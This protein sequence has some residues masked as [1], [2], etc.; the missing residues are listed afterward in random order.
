MI[1]NQA[2]DHTGAIIMRLR[3]GYLVLPFEKILVGVEKGKIYELAKNIVELLEKDTG[4][5]VLLEPVIAKINIDNERYV[6]TLSI[7]SL[8]ISSPET[9]DSNL[10]ENIN[11]KLW[12]IA[13]DVW[14]KTHSL[15]KKTNIYIHGFNYTK[16][17][18]VFKY[19][20]SR[21]SSTTITIPFISLT[22]DPAPYIETGNIVRSKLEIRLLRP[23]HIVV[24]GLKEVLLKG[25][26]EIE[27][28][29]VNINEVVK[30]PI[31]ILA[32]V[33]NYP[34]ILESLQTKSI[35]VLGK[36]IGRYSRKLEDLL[37]YNSIIYMLAN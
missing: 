22:R 1:K 28:Y 33:S 9:V 37:V 32:L 23:G 4:L 29:N 25:H 10:V 35:I 8:I 20:V 11:N 34:L 17:I 12:I 16:I 14:A 26:R 21:V 2:S 13:E 15:S 27:V 19:M 7:G 5:H 31:D 30:K 36:D 18:E 6:V 24:N 3:K